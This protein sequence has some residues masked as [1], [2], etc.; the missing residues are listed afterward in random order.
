LQQRASPGTHR[1]PDP[2]VPPLQFDMNRF[3]SAIAIVHKQLPQGQHAAAVS[4]LFNNMV[5]ADAFRGRVLAGGDGLPFFL[6]VQPQPTCMRILLVHTLGCLRRSGEVCRHSRHQH[7]RDWCPES[8]CEL[9][10]PDACEFVLHS[11]LLSGGSLLGG[12]NH[13]SSLFLPMAGTK[14]HRRYSRMWDGT[15]G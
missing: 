13:R 11:A 8:C 12:L 10:K 4:S 3:A 6:Q 1:P 14:P 7:R 15:A 9:E 2:T 5:R